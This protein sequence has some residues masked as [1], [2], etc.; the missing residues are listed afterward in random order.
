MSNVMPSS[1]LRWLI[2]L[3]GACCTFAQDAPKL[4]FEVATI[5]PSPPPDPGKGI[6]VGC[7]GGPGQSD[8]EMFRCQNMSPMNF[9]SRA[10]GLS[11]YLITAPDWLRS[12]KFDVTAKV[13]TGTTKEQFNIMLQN[14]LIDRFRLVTHRESK[15]VPKYDL[16]VAKNGPKLKE[17]VDEPA[18]KDDPTPFRMTMG[19]D[20]YPKLAPGRPG[21]AIM[22]DRARLFYPKWTME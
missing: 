10:F 5:K 4:E 9:I 3:A 1:C 11:Y 16:V 17:S 13:P 8:P 12:D 22:N 15:E 7:K 20:G 14:M 18:P 21:M 6:T 2:V 19:P